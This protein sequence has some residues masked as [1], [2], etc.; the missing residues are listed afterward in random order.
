[1]ALMYDSDDEKPNENLEKKLQHDITERERANAK[2]STK[3]ITDKT[4]LK[5]TD[6]KEMSRTEKRASEKFKDFLADDK[7]KTSGSS[8][9]LV[10]TPKPTSNDAKIADRFSPVA[11]TS[12]RKRSL[13]HEPTQSEKTQESP[14][15]KAKVSAPIA[16]EVVYKPFGKLLEGVVL[17]I[18]GIQNPDRAHIRDKA[19]R[20]G[21]K[22]K[23]DW[24]NTC[25]HLMYVVYYLFIIYRNF[26]NCICLR[27]AFKNTPKYNQVHGHGK[28]IKKD[29][30]S[31]CYDAKK[32]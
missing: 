29:W 3:V 30:I 27:C 14:L 7:P 19:L 5:K 8:S 9:T 15:K 32:R 26:W 22:Y 31:A 12:S 1:M 20:L 23:P 28:I 13:L 4:N 18:S 6:D 2:S 24:D 11:S 10:K 16:K 17:V 21:A 25:T